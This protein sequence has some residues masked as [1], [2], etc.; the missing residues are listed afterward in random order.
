MITLCYRPEKKHIK[1][2]N[3]NQKT[4]I[5]VVVVI[6]IEV[7]FLVKS[8]KVLKGTQTYWGQMELQKNW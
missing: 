3:L 8:G 2:S 6:V 7:V 5:V 4:G 1:I